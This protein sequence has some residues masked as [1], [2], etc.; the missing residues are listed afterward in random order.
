[1]E[2]INHKVL[3]LKYRPQ[4][5]KELIG[6]DAVVQTITNS[7]KSN[8]I[9]NAFILS[10]VRGTGKT[11]LARII[12][13]S[14]TCTGDFLE[15]KKCK[16]EGLCHCDEITNYKHLDVIEC[17]AASRT[18]VEDVREIIESAKYKPTTA[19]YKV[20][21]IDECHML[22]RSA[23]NAL[24]KTLEE[25]PEQL[26]FIFCTT[27][28]KKVPLTIISRCQT[29]NLHRVSIKTL[30]D[31]LKKISK[32][33]NGKISE[34][35]IK[36]IAKAGAGS[37]RD[38]LSLL[39]RALVDQY[40]NNNQTEESDVRKMLGIADR[41][42][43]LELLKFIFDGDQKKSIEYI[44]QMIDEG[45]D[46][47]NLKNDI[48]ELIYFILQKK[49][50]GDFDSDLNISES[51]LEIIDSI[52]KNINTSTL[53]IFWQFTLKA[54]EEDKLLTNPLLSLEMLV[55]RLM[56]LKETPSFEDLITENS[57]NEASLP[58][59]NEKIVEKILKKNE[60]KSTISKNQIKN[61]IQTKPEL[62]SRTIETS[63]KESI[64][65]LD[66][67]INIS[68]KKKEVQLKYDLE[69]NVNLIKFSEGKIDIS[70][71]ENLDKNFVRNLSEKLFEWT[72]NRWLITLAK[73][74]G[75]KTYSETQALKKKNL[76]DTEKK[77]EVYNKFKKIFS[78][79][80]LIEVSKKE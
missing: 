38:S 9:A 58:T 61:T 74:V 5:F 52:S 53:I 10:G 75:Q 40:L 8:R 7:I 47:V 30:S 63:S 17:D 20:Y 21:I 51:E 6:Q 56:H 27:E 66:D 71:N 22:S 11:S 24:L 29:F 32:L 50:L 12:S 37:V 39:D 76:L 62:I 78:D 36:L 42:K 25:P 1:M 19:K 46:A 18:G 65:S 67:L 2:K 80:E 73:E 48:L 44:R 26:K 23:W 4:N 3:A 70:F 60:E 28:L 57:S 41:S 64:K 33:E 15:S 59:S 79:A 45:L 68:S 16:K 13:K 72:G 35:A 31:H 55:I 54:L 49:N 43:I 69:N 34:A 14:L 77:K